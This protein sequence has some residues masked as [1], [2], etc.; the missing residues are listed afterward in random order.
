MIEFNDYY[1]LKKSTTVYLRSDIAAGTYTIKFNKYESDSKTYFRNILPITVTVIKADQT[2]LT[3]PT[4]TIN[5]ATFSTIG[6]PVQV[7]LIFSM[8]SST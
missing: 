2:N 8:P 3:R 4:I 5:S 7:P 1:T 6:Y